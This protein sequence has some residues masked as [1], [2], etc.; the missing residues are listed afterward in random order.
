MAQSETAELRQSE[1][2]FRVLAEYSSDLVTVL[3]ANGEITYI[4]PSVERIGGY[5]PEAA[6]GRRFSE[7]VHPDD[8][9]AAAGQFADTLANPQ[10]SHVSELRYRHN[11]GAW[12]TLEV[13]AHNL[14]ADA[15]VRGI[16]INARDITQRKQSEQALTLF[17]ALLDRSSDAIEVVDPETL[18]YLDVN[19]TAC[20]AL[21]YSRDEFLS[22]RV[23][24]IDT[25]LDQPRI[26]CVNRQL[27][28]HGR[29]SFETVHR[30][31]DG[32]RYPVDVHI[33]QVQLDRLYNVISV[34]DITERKQAERAL[35]RLNWALRALSQSNS[36]LIHAGDEQTLFQACC[37][38]ITR[39]G[40]YPLAWIG[41]ARDDSARSVEI[42]A[43]AGVACGYLAG[44][45]LSWGEA[46]PVGCGP[47]G[48]AI[49]TGTTQV[50]NDPATS[51]S[52]RPWL[53]RARA[54]GLASGVAVPIRLD[55]GIFG[56]LVVYSREPAA[57]G[58]EEVHLVE[59]LAADIG[60]G[61]TVRRTRRAYEA[62]LEERAQQAAKLRATFE[63]VITALATTVEQRDPYT[64]GHQRRV[65]DLAVAIGQELG[66]DADRSEGLRIAASIHDI[67]KIYVP[68]RDP[69]AAGAAAP[70]R[71]RDR[72][73]PCP[74]GL[75]YRQG[76]RLSV[77]G[78]RD[79]VPAS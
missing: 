13:R 26:E 30:R 12:L 34:R 28:A 48:L 59:E 17:R 75:R 50:F 72:Q 69:G 14:L 42:L 53:E 51:A 55:S 15:A 79:L 23:W 21:G 60:Y 27:Q 32:S 4:S 39:S 11:S 1:A 73:K 78:S 2:R 46:R 19:Q 40:V 66:L 43:S 35:K 20:E 57:F 62:G 41:I 56:V 9:A 24:D 8:A 36:A 31:K 6:I 68:G 45:E 29:A 44:I 3:D 71:V 5:R 16:L 47:A 49:R 33:R 70:D 64:A 7:L 54:N 77:A 61:I 10:Q 65:A 74:G 76:H 22:L 63:S 58:E 67:G 25:G 52:Y 38:A 18:C 37:D